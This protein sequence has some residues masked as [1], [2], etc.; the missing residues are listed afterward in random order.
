MCFSSHI[1]FLDEIA[2]ENAGLDEMIAKAD[3]LFKKRLQNSR[4]IVWNIEPFVLNQ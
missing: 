3:T 4:Y 2:Y 1:S